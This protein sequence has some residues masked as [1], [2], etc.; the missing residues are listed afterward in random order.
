MASASAVPSPGVGPRA[1]GAPARQPTAHVDADNASRILD[2]LAE[3]KSRGR[4]VL[5]TTHDPRL[6]GRRPRR[7]GASMSAG[8]LAP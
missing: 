6:L 5:A 1:R 2:L 3:E 7:P 8:R 4:A